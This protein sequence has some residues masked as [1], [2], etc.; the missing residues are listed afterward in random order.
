MKKYSETRRKIDEFYHQRGKYAPDA[1][2]FITDCVIRQVSA[3]HE[4]RHLSARE[5]LLGLKTQMQSA[6]G[7]MAATVLREWKIS[8]A[9]DIGEIVFDLINLGILSASEEDQR[10]D[11]DIDFDLLPLPPEQN[12]PF[13]EQEIPQID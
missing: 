5:L 12:R 1:Y 3:L 7:F 2:E 8:S 6:F 10:G 13:S 9:S 11:F 4:P